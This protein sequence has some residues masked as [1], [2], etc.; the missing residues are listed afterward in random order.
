M[1]I[2]KI[3]RSFVASGS[4][5]NFSFFSFDRIASHTINTS[6]MVDNTT[7]PMPDVAQKL[8]RQGTASPTPAQQDTSNATTAPS[9]NT[10]IQ[11]ATP[12]AATDA[13]PAEAQQSLPELGGE[14][15]DT[16]F[17]S[18]LGSEQSSGGTSITSRILNGHWSGGRRYQATK[19]TAWSMPS[20]DKQFESMVS[21][22]RPTIP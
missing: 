12:G 11:A 16:E 18:A 8:S 3:S 22:D 2:M 6:K 7:S 21:L 19:D 9:A 13:T 10:A 5:A 1:V 4:T 20:D 14:A 15:H 17:D